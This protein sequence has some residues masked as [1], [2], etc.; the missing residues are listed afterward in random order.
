MEYYTIPKIN[1][2]A[3]YSEHNML[4]Y[5]DSMTSFVGF[6][7]GSVGKESACSTRDCL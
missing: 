2:T 6:P 7:S 4:N 5:V 3:K 1:V